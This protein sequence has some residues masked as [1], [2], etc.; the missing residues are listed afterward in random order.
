MKDCG[1]NA[2]VYEVEQ[3]EVREAERIERLEKLVRGGFV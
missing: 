1:T 3:R 2:A